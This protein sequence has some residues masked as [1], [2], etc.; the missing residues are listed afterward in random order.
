[1]IQTRAKSLVQLIDKKRILRFEKDYIQAYTTR[2]EQ[3]QNV[4]GKVVQLYSRLNLMRKHNVCEFDYEK[5]TQSLHGLC[6]NLQKQFNEKPEWI[7]E[8]GALRQLS[9]KVETVKSQ[10]D[11]ELKAKWKEYI[12]SDLPSISNEML[13]IMVNIP[14]FSRKVSQIKRLYREISEQKE[15]LPLQEKELLSVLKK[16]EELINEWNSLGTEDV[17]PTVLKFIRSASSHQGAA[18]QYLT[19]EVL[20]WLKKYKIQSF[21]KIRIQ[22]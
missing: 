14:S 8:Q 5:D 3:L 1:M 6:I 7:K 11:E 19:P 21:F 9:L 13:D 17:P 15:I 18:L 10:I 12:E 2:K 4:V 20:V 16:K 22:S